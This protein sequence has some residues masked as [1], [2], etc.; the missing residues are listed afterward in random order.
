MTSHPNSS[1]LVRNTATLTLELTGLRNGDGVIYA[2]LFSGP[3][4][5]PSN[6]A[7]ALRSGQFPIE[8]VP[9]QLSFPDLPFGQYAAT[10]H[11][12]ENMDGQLNVNALGIPKEGIGFSR[13][14]RIWQGIPPFHR[15]KFDFTPR[16]TV[17]AIAV[18]YLL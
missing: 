14:P 3:N 12:D 4:G 15:A 5:F 7:S 17:I 10:V 11:H 18:K 2:A 1:T 6:A 16:N 8:Q 9:L 13:N